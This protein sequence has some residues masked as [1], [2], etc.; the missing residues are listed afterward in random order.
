MT[1]CGVKSNRIISEGQI[2]SVLIYLH[3]PIK[4]SKNLEQW[5][6]TIEHDEDGNI[7]LLE[8][9][10]HLL[11]QGYLSQTL[12]YIRR[13]LIDVIIG[14][15]KYKQIYKRFNYYESL[16]IVDPEAVT[17][18]N[19]TRNNVTPANNND[20][21]TQVPVVPKEQC[22]FKCVRQYILKYPPDFYYNYFPDKNVNKNEGIVLIRKRFGYSS[23]PNTMSSLKLVKFSKQASYNKKMKSLSPS[24]PHT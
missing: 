21:T 14:D 19:N 4:F 11:T 24:T 3:V 8:L 12:L 10:N 1:I 15:Y 18:S 5:L 6:P 22:L 17:I 23:R 7:N 20:N 16:S 9:V 13:Q 2:R